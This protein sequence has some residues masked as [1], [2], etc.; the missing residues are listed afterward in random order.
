[1]KFIVLIHG[2]IKIEKQDMRDVHSGNKK[3]PT[4]MWLRL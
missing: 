3:K 4:L 2:E 1:M